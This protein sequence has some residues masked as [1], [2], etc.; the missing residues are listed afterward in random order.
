MEKP[1]IHKFSWIEMFNDS[2]GRTSPSKFLGFLGGVISLLVF[3]LCG[4]AIVTKF[5]DGTNVGNVSIQSVAMFT[6]AS[7]LLGI[8][9]FT[10]DKDYEQTE[11]QDII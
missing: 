5:A 3:L 1:D 2:K 7:A 11:N 9:R 6:V 4:V 10:K 8:R